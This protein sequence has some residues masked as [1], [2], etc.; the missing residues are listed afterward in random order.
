MATKKQALIKT[1]DGKMQV[2]VATDTSDGTAANAGRFLLLNDSGI[3]DESVIP[4]WMKGFL[5]K[6]NC[7][8]TGGIAVGKIVALT[9]TGFVLADNGSLA[10]DAI[11]IAVTVGVNNAQ[12]SVLTGGKFT[13]SGAAF[14]KGSN[15]FLGTGGD[16][17]TIPPDNVANKLSQKIG[18]AL[19]PTQ[20]VLEI[21]EPIITSSL[22]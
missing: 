6:D 1:T 5:V 22:N 20:M 21:S 16:V 9:A 11:G 7:V 14:T 4:D 10:K 15:Y 17:T 8:E 3:V 12:M 18:K 19:A 13:I 2:S